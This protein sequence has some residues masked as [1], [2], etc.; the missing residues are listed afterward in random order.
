MEEQVEENLNNIGLGEYKA[1]NRTRWKEGVRAIAERMR[2][3]CPPSTKTHRIETGCTAERDSD[4]SG[5]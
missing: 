5:Y 2:C 1:A 3:V 4:V